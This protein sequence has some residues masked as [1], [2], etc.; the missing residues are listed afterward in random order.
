MRKKFIVDDRILKLNKNIVD[1]IGFAIA[2]RYVQFEFM[3]ELMCLW[4]I[5]RSCESSIWF[6]V[7]K[8]NMI[9]HQWV[10]WSLHH[11]NSQYVFITSIEQSSGFE[12]HL[13]WQ[14]L[15]ECLNAFIPLSEVFIIESSFSHCT[16][17]HV[18]DMCPHT[19]SICKTDFR[20]S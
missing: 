5:V 14:V 3:I 18:L 6:Y 16:F 8:I 12:I 17:I 1:I 9:I 11:V 13:I 10:S 7:R 20:L 15:L 2:N 19:W 4:R